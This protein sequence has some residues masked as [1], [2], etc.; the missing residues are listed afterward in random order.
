MSL[1]VNS[2]QYFLLK[3][4]S[5]GAYILHIQEGHAI[6]HF[7]FYRP[8]VAL[9]AFRNNFF[10]FSFWPFDMDCCCQNKTLFY[11]KA[12][13]LNEIFLVPLIPPINADLLSE[14]KCKIL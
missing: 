10:K 6:S 14:E 2:L 13:V 11:G 12:I 3:L 8:Q 7:S 4:F 9:S 5:N 1:L